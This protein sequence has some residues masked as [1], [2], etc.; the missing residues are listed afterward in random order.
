MKNIF[1]TCC[2][3]IL[4]FKSAQAQWQKVLGKNSV[5]AS[6][7]S[8]TQV[9]NNLYLFD[10]KGIYFSQDKGNVWRKLNINTF[11]AI[12]DFTYWAYLANEKG[13]FTVVSKKYSATAKDSLFLLFSSNLGSSFQIIKFLDAGQFFLDKKFFKFQQIGDDVLLSIRDLKIFLKINKRTLT[14][15]TKPVITG[16]ILYTSSVAEYIFKAIG[17][18]YFMDIKFTNGT[19][20]TKPMPRNTY[21][22]ADLSMLKDSLLYQYGQ[23]SKDFGQTWYALGDLPPRLD[24]NSESYFFAYKNKLYYIVNSILYVSLDDGRTWLLE[25]NEIQKYCGGSNS[26]F[27]VVDSILT[28]NAC[29]K[30]NSCLEKFTYN[31]LTKKITY[32]NTEGVPRNV[33][34]YFD[35]ITRLSNG[36]LLK[37]STPYLS[38]ISNDNGATWQPETAYPYFF[39]RIQVNDSTFYAVDRY[40]PRDVNSFYI[41]II[42]YVNNRPQDTLSASSPLSEIGHQN[43]GFYQSGDTV[44]GFSV[45]LDTLIYSIKPFTA[46]TK[47]P[48][49]KNGGHRFGYFENKKLYAFTKDIQYGYNYLDIISLD[50][51]IQNVTQLNLRGTVQSISKPNNIWVVN[52]TNAYNTKD[53]GVTTRSISIIIS[54]RY[55]STYDIENSI[56]IDIKKENIPNEQVLMFVP[57]LVNT[58]YISVDSGKTWTFFNLGLEKEQVLSIQQVNNY[59]YA[60]T[61]NAMYRRSIEDISLRSASGTVYF[62]DN[63][64]NR[65]DFNERPVIGTK[66]Y[67]PVSNAFSITDSSGRYSILADIEGVDTVRV[68]FDNKYASIA[69]PFH[70]LTQSDSSKNFAIR[71]T[72]NITDVQITATALTPSRPG[73]NTEYQLNY[74]NVGS[75]AVSGTLRFNYTA[76]QNFVAASAPPSSN[77]NQV[78]TWAYADL[79]PNESRIL[80]FI[81]KTAANVPLR[82]QLTNI[83]NITPLSN[84]TFKTDNVDTLIQIVVGSYDPNDKQVTFNNSKTPPSV[85]DPSTELIYTIRFQNTGNY[86]ADFVKVVDTLSEKLDLSTFRLIATSHKGD[87]SVR[88]KNVLI[89]D[90]NPIYLPDSLRDEKGSHGFV[91]FAIKPKKTLT[92]DEAIKNTGYIYF[93]YNEAIVTNTVETANQKINSVFTPSVSAGK[94]DISP[95]PTQ[96]I[97]TI[98]IG[99]ADFKEGNLSIYDL[100]GRLMLTKTIA[101][102]TGVVDV[103]HLNVGEY[104][105]TVK[106]LDN[107]VFVSKF[108]KVQ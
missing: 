28:F 106:A 16:N 34:S 76:Q 55:Y 47:V 8:A 32:L 50:G 60:N 25:S 72:P 95:N 98:E 70:V 105:C 4:S 71:L 66:V 59:L 80:K 30:Y 75:T 99:D 58:P 54:N 51:S 48:L 19:T 90:F 65:F 102:K 53:W 79:Q 86:P 88:N 20:V 37:G 22:Y 46:I 38:F 69:P 29:Q 108:V 64:N 21:A 40:A 91:K 24:K 9:G 89:F 107:K 92:K 97:L 2:L 83:A 87:V 33:S 3:C 13:V 11:N 5:P 41:P 7:A 52:G 42:R 45:K 31:L 104:I 81:L 43:F 23:L 67:S 68:S 10:E 100:S 84:D 63:N 57:Y 35:T 61:A 73:F 44:V 27:S 17:N 74:K 78:L 12:D 49:T 82:T 62:D 103:S 36:R 85:I 15:E 14:I 56:F 93:D 77:V 94:L 96:N 18:D 39:E 26:V 1:I 101:H 6:A